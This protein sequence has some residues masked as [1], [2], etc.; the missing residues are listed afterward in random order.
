MYACIVIYFSYQVCIYISIPPINTEVRVILPSVHFHE[1]FPFLH[2]GNSSPPNTPSYDFPAHPSMHNPLSLHF[3]QFQ[4]LPFKSPLHVTPTYFGSIPKDVYTLTP[5]SPSSTPPR[6]GRRSHT[7]ANTP[8]PS[9]P[10]SPSSPSPPTLVSRFLLPS[11][12]SRTPSTPCRLEI[13]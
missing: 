7:S 11:A 10:R 3:P 9:T 1:Q 6:S 12:A 4:P 5:S 13:C 8:S 2:R